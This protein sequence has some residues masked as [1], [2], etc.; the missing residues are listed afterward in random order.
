MANRSE[1]ISIEEAG[2]RFSVSR[3]TSYKLARQGS[4]GGVP[5]L[6]VG[7]KFRVSTRAMDEVLGVQEVAA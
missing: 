7:H 4:I 2:R 6:R 3:T 5:V 1:T